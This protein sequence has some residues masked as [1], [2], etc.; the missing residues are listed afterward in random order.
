MRF[1]KITDNA[2]SEAASSS[3][4]VEMLLGC[5]TRIRHYVQ[6]SL[7][8]AGAENEPLKE[9]AEAATAIFRYFSTAL[10]LHEADE[11]K[12]IFPRLR[13]AQ[14]AGGLVR[15]AAEIMVEQH[16]AIDEMATELL[17][18][19]SSLD[20]TP[21]RLATLSRRLEHVSRALEQAFAAHLH[22]EETVIFPALT[23]LLTGEQLEEIRREMQERRT[24]PRNGI[25][26]VQ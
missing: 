6:L 16:K 5:H 8:L 24:A 15:E 23:E 21:E 3:T 26:L 12:S 25:H 9:I 22:M 14:P 2:E 7:T 10:P 11:N 20:H 1:T 17:S 13:S 4:A 18:L 19:C